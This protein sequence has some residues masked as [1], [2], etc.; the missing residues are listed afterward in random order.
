LGVYFALDSGTADSIVYDTIVEETGSS[1]GYE[2]WAGRLQLVESI[3]LVVSALAGGL[4]AD[5]ISPRFTYLATAPVVTLAIVAFLRCREPRLH[6]TAERITFRR[7]AAATL[8]ALGATGAIRRV[9]LLSAVAATTAQV[10]FDFGPLWLVSMHAPAVVYGPYW[11]ALLAAV[12][13]GAWVVSRLPFG[14]AWV[15]LLLGVAILL[16]ALASIA[17]AA[18]P[19]VIA[20]QI[21]LASVVSMLGIRAGFLMH[22]AVPPTLRAG[23]SSGAS[24]LAWATFLPVAVVFGAISRSHGIHAAG[25]ILVAIAVVLAV[26]CPAVRTVP[27]GGQEA[28]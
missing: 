7:Q 2:R 26:L 3:V 15:V 1:D 17:A 21:V 22:E 19:V 25:W 27:R 6:R 24:T 5:L 16:A 20:A 14:R 13:L 8:R 28:A 23:V 9:V 18:L 11:A 10:L 12:G 4:L